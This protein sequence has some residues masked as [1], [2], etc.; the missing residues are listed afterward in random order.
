MGAAALRGEERRRGVS[1]HADFAAY[2]DFA[3]HMKARN[4]GYGTGERAEP[5]AA[6][7][8]DSV[9]GLLDTA[10]RLAGITL[11]T[12]AM[13]RALCETDYLALSGATFPDYVTYE[14]MVEF[15]RKTLTPDMDEAAEMRRYAA[16]AQF[17]RVP[18]V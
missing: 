1:H 3:A 9:G 6:P 13:G 4:E 5:A 7:L 12:D 8:G 10:I 15:N 11:P 16:I 18:H 14:Q 2:R 17:W